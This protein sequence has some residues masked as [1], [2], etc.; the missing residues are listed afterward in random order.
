[1]KVTRPSHVPA[2]HVLPS[3]R[4]TPYL[5]YDLIASPFSPSLIFA[6]LSILSRICSS[7][8]QAKELYIPGVFVTARAGDELVA[9]ATT[10]KDGTE[11]GDPQRIADGRYGAGGLTVRFETDNAV[12]KAWGTLGATAWPEDILGA[13][14]LAR[15]LR[16]SRHAVFVTGLHRLNK[17]QSIPQIMSQ[18][19]L[20]VRGVRR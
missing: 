4:R 20:G 17:G 19:Y 9:A 10:P 7:H 12:G 6:C 5:T 18:N 16:V 3:S 13:R 11:N 14:V 15:Q 1:M 8:A 2:E